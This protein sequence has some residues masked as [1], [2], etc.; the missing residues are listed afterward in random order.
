MWTQATKELAYTLLSWEYE[1]E[2]SKDDQTQGHQILQLQ[3]QG[4]SL[5]SLLNQL[6]L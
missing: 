6:G 4:W 2:A 5:C 1:E 3:A